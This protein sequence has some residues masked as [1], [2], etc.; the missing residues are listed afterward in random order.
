VDLFA[1]RIKTTIASLRAQLPAR[2]DAS[3]PRANGARS[4]TRR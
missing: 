3:T 2:I 4:H 1:P